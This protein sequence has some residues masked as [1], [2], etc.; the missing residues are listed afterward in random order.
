MANLNKNIAKKSKKNT[1]FN[2]D[3]MLLSLLKKNNAKTMFKYNIL[4]PF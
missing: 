2:P 1:D 4:R 3:S